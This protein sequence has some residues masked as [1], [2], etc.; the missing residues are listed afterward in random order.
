MT[1]LKFVGDHIIRYATY[2]LVFV[3]HR[4]YALCCIVSKI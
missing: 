3:L 4:D 2:N 1:S